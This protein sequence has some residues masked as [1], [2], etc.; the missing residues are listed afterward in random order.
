M[1]PKILEITIATAHVRNVLDVM[2]NMQEV[3][4]KGTM[5]KDLVTTD[6]VITDS[7]VV[8]G[9]MMDGKVAVAGTVDTI[10]VE[11]ITNPV[12][13]VLLVV[14]N[15]IINHRMILTGETAEAA[16][17]VIDNSPHT[18]VVMPAVTEVLPTIILHHTVGLIITE[19]NKAGITSIRT[20]TLKTSS[21][22]RR[23]GAITTTVVV[24][25]ATVEITVV[26]EVVIVT[27]SRARH[28][29]S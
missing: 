8:V 1:L 14:I 3:K 28:A 17:E 6:N 25:I 22:D 24:I 4:E 18:V 11:V 7:Q 20:R 2:T 13:V 26:A 10:K 15:L 5:N 29:R 9:D 23:T 27:N 21:G 19:T 12:T 16:A